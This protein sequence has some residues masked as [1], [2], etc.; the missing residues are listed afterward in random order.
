MRL[1][2]GIPSLA[3]YQALCRSEG[4]AALEAF[5]DAFL[6][7]NRDT[8]VP[9]ARRWAADPLRNWS[10]RWE[11]PFVLGAL[12]HD[13]DA[14]DRPPDRILDAGSGATFFP[15]ALAD[16]FAGARIA[17]CDLDGTLAP[18]FGRLRH[19]H[20]PR[21]TFSI[22]ALQGLPFRT[23]CFDAVAC[24][25]VLEHTDAFEHILD[26]FRRVLRPG[27][28][29]LVTFDI[30]LDGRSDIDPAGAERLLAAIGARFESESAMAATALPQAIAASGILTTAWAREHDPDALPWRRSMRGDVADL[31]RGRRPRRPFYHCTVACGAWRRPA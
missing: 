10:R 16:R 5:S 24:V 28:L 30:S 14:S 1:A 8:L 12:E 17:C 13:L 23:N 29:L 21:V 22:A 7:A 27:G 31:L 2:P 19:A 3:E 4:F 15:F 9:Y 11:Y 26:E 25:S 18:L 20:R 6:A